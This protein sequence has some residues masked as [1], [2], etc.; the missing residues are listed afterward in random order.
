MI[1]SVDLLS[2]H[3]TYTLCTNEYDKHHLCLF[4][5]GGISLLGRLIDLLRG[6]LSVFFSGLLAHE[7][8]TNSTAN[9]TNFVLTL[10]ERE[11]S[12]YN[13]GTKSPGN[14][15]KNPEGE[16]GL[17]EDLSR[18]GENGP[19]ND[20]NEGEE[21][22]TTDNPALG[23][24]NHILVHDVLGKPRIILLNKVDVGIKSSK[25]KVLRINELGV[26]IVD[27]PRT[28]NG[29][30]VSREHDRVRSESGDVDGTTFN[31]GSNKP[32]DEGKNESTPCRNDSSLSRS[33]I[34]SHHVPERDD[35]RSNYNT[36]E[37]VDPS[38][39]KTHGIKCNRKE[40]H[41]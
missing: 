27:E 8:V 20:K 23:T 38:K 26:D 7:E 34:P 25:V 36:H 24:A 16:V 14:G 11:E 3:Q 32:G 31:G 9:L 19:H 21:V 33:L 10:K 39:V 30:Q 18:D 37:E 29:N 17:R 40:T 2:A 4:F 41:E 28:Q 6:L 15:H 12:N 13:G 35:S 5:G 1:K 22:S